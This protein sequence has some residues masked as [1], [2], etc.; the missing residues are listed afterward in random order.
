LGLSLGSLKR[1]A[2]DAIQEMNSGSNKMLL[3]LPPRAFPRHS[4]EL[5]KDLGL[6][7]GDLIEALG[8]PT[9]CIS[10]PAAHLLINGAGATEEPEFLEQTLWGKNI[11]SIQFVVKLGPTFWKTNSLG[12]MLRRL[13]EGPKDQYTWPI[14]E[15][16]LGLD[17]TKELD[18]V[19]SVLIAG[20]SGESRAVAN[21]IAKGLLVGRFPLNML[22][23]EIIFAI[24]YWTEKPVYCCGEKFVGGYCPNCR[25]VPPSPQADLIRSLGKASLINIEELAYYTKSIRSDIVK[26]SVDC[27]A[28]ELQRQPEI[29]DQFAKGVLDGRFSHA[30]IKA[31]FIT[32]NHLL[33]DKQRILLELLSSGGEEIQLICL[34]ELTVAIWDFPQQIAEKVLSLTQD[35]NARVRNAATRAMRSD[36]A[37]SKKKIQLTEGDNMKA[38]YA[39]ITALR[40]E[41]DAVRC[42]DTNWEKVYSDK[43]IQTY[44]RTKIQNE[45]NANK[46]VVAFSCFGMGRV[47]AA[48]ATKDVI[49]D[50]NPDV[51]LLLGI[52]AGLFPDKQIVG[53]IVVPDQIIDYELQKITSEGREDRYQVYRPDALLLNRVKNFDETSWIKNIAFDPSTLNLSRP[54]KLHTSGD[55]LCGDKVDD[56]GSVASEHQSQWPKAQALEMESAGVASAIY[57]TINQRRMIIIK[58]ISDF[59]NGDQ[60]EDAKLYAAHTSATFAFALV[61]SL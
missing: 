61:K 13:E 4:W 46:I 38:D 47:Q 7:T 5:A 31:I 39:I 20:L 53:D 54:P 55:I 36:V 34:S 10:L 59:V 43:T 3:F 44:Y 25:V 18:R 24:K 26:A 2:V 22:K 27:I 9:L 50:F 33:A 11:R 30:S 37:K 49:N 17:C 1:D 48:N 58:G 56:N 32:Y 41:L 60:P 14:Y 42:Y 15:S 29:L 12:I 19:K 51:I 45:R 8:Y 23:D 16:I 6:P 28:D 52:T 57:Q 35:Q 21:G 40:T